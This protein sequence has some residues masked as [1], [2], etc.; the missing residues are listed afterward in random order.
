M[1]DPI[2][3]STTTMDQPAFAAWVGSRPPHDEH[4]YEPLSGRI[5][6]TP[7]AGW[8]HG[9]VEARLVARISAAAA[10]HALGGSE[11]GLVFGSSQGFELPTG[12]TVEPDASYVSRERWRAAPTPEHGKFLAVVPALD[13]HERWNSAVLPNLS[14]CAADLQPH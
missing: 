11:Q 13:E 1:R 3:E 7:P 10:P 8:P 6:M 5:V 4:H 2:F 14:L 12:D 9:N